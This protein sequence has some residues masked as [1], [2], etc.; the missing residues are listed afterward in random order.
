MPEKPKVEQWRKKPV[1]IE[2]I[3][4][5]GTH[6]RTQQII[7][8]MNASNPRFDPNDSATWTVSGYYGTLTIK[9]LEGEMTASKGDWI[10]RGVKGE[11][12]PCKPDI[13]AATYEPAHVPTPAPPL[14]KIL[15][16]IA[17]RIRWDE[18]QS[19]QHGDRTPFLDAMR[20]LASAPAPAP[21]PTAGN[22]LEYWLKDYAQFRP[23][24]WPLIQEYL[25][26]A[27]AA[28]QGAPDGAKLLLALE[29]IADLAENAVGEN[30]YEVPEENLMQ[31]WEIA[32][33]ALPSSPVSRKED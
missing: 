26:S 22:M 1:V 30:A 7:E 6:D 18:V 14:D 29:E 31:V 33:R 8:W 15:A 2:A 16:G 23:N 21:E 12:Y 17:L 13:F 3:Q 10:I 28:A 20:R 19:V 24:W 11:F 25:A 5:D 27:L 32:R 9:T 4:H